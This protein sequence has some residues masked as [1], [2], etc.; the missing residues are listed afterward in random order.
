MRNFPGGCGISFV[1]IVSGIIICA[2]VQLI[3]NSESTEPYYESMEYTHDS[4]SFSCPSVYV[5]NQKSYYNPILVE[6]PKIRTGSVS[7]DGA[8]DEGYDEGYEHGLDDG[9]RGRSH[10][11]SYDESNDYYNHYETMYEEGYEEGYNEG[12]DEGKSYYNN[13]VVEED[14][15]D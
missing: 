10:G 11:Y 6:P 3:M 13:Y 7:P 1:L 15:E 2:F 9:K 12:Y 4:T 8:Y 5:S 14:D